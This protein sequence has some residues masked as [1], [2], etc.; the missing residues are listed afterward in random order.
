MVEV[1]DYIPE[2]VKDRVGTDATGVL[3]QLR[4]TRYSHTSTFFW[5]P[6]S[7]R[8]KP[9]PAETALFVSQTPA[10]FSSQQSEALG[11]VLL[12]STAQD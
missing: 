6:S 7:A 10:Q 9:G 5:I 12:A 4:S 3:E 1:P 11:L 8:L 2:P